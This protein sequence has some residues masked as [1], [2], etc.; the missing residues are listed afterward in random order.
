M[1]KCMSFSIIALRHEYKIKNP[2]KVMQ[3]YKNLQPLT[4]VLFGH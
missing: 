1:N 3:N 2:Q 4:N